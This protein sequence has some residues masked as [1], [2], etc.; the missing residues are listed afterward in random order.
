MTSEIIETRGKYRARIVLD[1]HPSE[2]YDD[3]ATPIVQVRRG[4]YW[5]WSGEQA[6]GTSYKVPGDIIEAVGRFG[7]DSDLLERYLRIFHGVTSVKWYDSGS[8]TY[9]SFVSP[10]WLEYVGEPRDNEGIKADLTEWIAYC[11]GD[12]W[13][14]VVEELTTWQRTDVPTYGDP[15]IREEWDE[16]D[17]VW[18]HYG[19]KW[20]VEAAKEQLDYFADE[21][22][23]A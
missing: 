6:G 7:S 12:V 23:P 1:K 17:S 14:V 21:E 20:A 8:Y 10:D 3:G 5:G 16:V 2:P 11:E 4:G 19:Y 13:G 15:I 18:G 22:V 9:F